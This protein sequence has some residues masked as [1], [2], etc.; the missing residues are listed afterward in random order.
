MKFKKV[1]I[2]PDIHYPEQSESS[3][4]LVKKFIKDVQP[5][6]VIYQ[7]DNLDMGVISHW[8]KDKKKTLELKRLKKDY[9]GFDKDVLL[10]IENLVN[11]KTK[12]IWLRGN[13]EDW[14]DQYIDKNPEME[15]LI[16]PEVC[17]KLEERNYKIVPYNSVYKLGKLNIIHGYYHSKYHSA[18]T[19]SVF[20][21]S[22]CYGH[23]HSPQMHSKTKPMDSSDF[24]AS[25]GLPCLCDL[26]PDYMKNRPN[27]WINGF[28]F[29]YVFPDGTFNLYTIV[30]VNNKFI[31]NGKIY[32]S[33]KKAKVRSI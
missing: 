22:I 15:G 11:K 33:N 30:I 27:S 23:V 26:A 14:A 19:L 1:V 24:H 25:Y 8:N 12:F 29:V 28:G 3:L 6:E 21:E 17:L 5:D 13:H 20:E 16:E 9:E 18:K 32:E 7:G 4:D 2:L 10:P 31:W